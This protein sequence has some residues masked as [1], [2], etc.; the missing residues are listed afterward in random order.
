[1]TIKQRIIDLYG[2]GFLQRSALNFDDGEETFDRVL[3]GKGY[4]TIVEIGTC[5]GCSAAVMAQHCDLVVTFDLQNGR[6]ERIGLPFDRNDLWESLGIENIELVLVDDDR[7]KKKI[8]DGMQFD[9]AFIDGAHDFD[10]VQRDFEMVRRCGR[11]LFH[12]QIRRHRP[13]KKDGVCD[14][15]DTLPQNQIEKLDMFAMWR[16]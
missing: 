10:S 8:L 15:V 4:R 14:F 3:A 11:V 13:F 16:A 1:M 2:S 12:D 7:E 9:F 5:R 6:L